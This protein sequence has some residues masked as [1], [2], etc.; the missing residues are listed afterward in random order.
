MPIT[1][2]PTPPSRADSVNFAP[3]GDAFMAALPT[4]ATE[5]NTLQA[6]VTTKQGQAAASQA[7]GANSEANALASKNAAATSEA[8]AATSASSASGSASTALAS[9]NAAATSEANASNSATAAAASA[10]SVNDANLVHKTGNETIAGNKTFSGTTA[11]ITKSM[12]GLGNVDNTADASKPVSTLQ[13]SAIAARFGKD[14]ILGTVSQ[15]SG[16]PTGALM[17]HGTN[18]N[19]EYWRFA[20]GL[21]I[22]IGN[23]QPGSVGLSANGACFISSAPQG[24]NALPAVFLAGTTP[25]FESFLRTDQGVAWLTG[26]VAGSTTNF[27]QSYLMSAG[28]T[29][30]TGT[31]IDML[32]VGRWF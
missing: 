4:F 22:C 15:T 16:T 27:P 24:G 28:G 1:P 12:V 29:T 2:L 20:G 30:L 9:K 8:N 18:I 6:D 19:G 14:N 32:A 3:R 7:A 25:S 17:E 11:G 21:Q 23:I 26:A 5:A 13:A 10:A 31:R